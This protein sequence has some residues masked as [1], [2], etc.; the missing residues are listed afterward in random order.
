MSGSG[1]VR[2]RSTAVEELVERPA[3]D[4]RGD[5]GAA[6]RAPRRAARSPSAAPSVSASGFSWLTV[7]TRGAPRTALDDCSARTRRAA[8]VDGHQ[9]VP[10][11]RRASADV[12]RRVDVAVALAVPAT[13]A[14]CRRRACER[15]AV[16]GRDGLRSRGSRRR[17]Q[18]PWQA[19]PPRGEAERTGVGSDSRTGASASGRSRCTRARARRGCAARG[20]RARPSRRARTC[21][22]GMRRRRSR[23]PS[24]CRTNGIARRARASVSSPLGRAADDADPD[25]ARGTGPAWS[26]RR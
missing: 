14:A 15:A 26:R 8:Q 24:S 22:S 1:S 19:C 20:C 6:R 11:R 4:R 21:S 16:A 9:G 2:K 7:R 17:R 25:L 13:P 5:R 18:A 10:R 12:G 23:T 3:R